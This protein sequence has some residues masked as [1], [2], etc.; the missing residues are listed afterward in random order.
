LGFIPLSSFKRSLD[1]YITA[2]S[3]PRSILAP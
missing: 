2:Y 3:E 1:F